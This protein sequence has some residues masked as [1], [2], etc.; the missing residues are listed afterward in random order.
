[1]TLA[2]KLSHILTVRDDEEALYNAL[3]ELSEQQKTIIIVA[4]VRLLDEPE[5]AVEMF[6]RME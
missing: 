4:F 2:D 6:R 1:M 3:D 5:K